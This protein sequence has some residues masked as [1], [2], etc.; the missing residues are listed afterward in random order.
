[1]PPVVVLLVLTVLILAQLFYALSPRRATY[2]R[3]LLIALAGVALGE[4]LGSRLL[5]PGPRLGELH[6]LWDLGLSA[7][8][9]LLANRFGR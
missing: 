2:L 4:F 8:L 7:P 5:A 1:M 3:R 6:P 9:Q